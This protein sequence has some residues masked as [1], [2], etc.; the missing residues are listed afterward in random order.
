M[1][2]RYVDIPFSSAA[3]LEANKLYWV[4]IA[5]THNPG[6]FISSGYHN[7][8]NGG[9][10]IV[11]Y[12]TSGF[13][14]SFP[15]VLS[16]SNLNSHGEFAYWF[17]LYDPDASFLTGPQGPTGAAGPLPL[18]A[19]GNFDVSCNN[20]VDVSG[21][22]FCDGT[23]IGS[24]DSFDISMVNQNFKIKTIDNE[25]AFNI[26]PSGN[27]GIGAAATSRR[28][29]VRSKASDTNPTTIPLELDTDTQ[30]SCGLR[31]KCADASGKY[32]LWD[33]F[34]SNG[35]Q[36]QGWGVYDRDQSEYR[37]VIDGSS[38]N[39]GIGT[40]DPVARL[41]I[42]AN[43]GYAANLVESKTKAG[44][45]LNSQVDGGSNGLSIGEDTGTGS[46][47][48]S[49]S[50]TGGTTSY[51]INLNPWG[52]NV[53]IGT[54]DPKGVLHLRQKAGTGGTKLVFEDAS[55]NGAPGKFWFVNV[56]DGD[57]S[58]NACTAADGSWCTS[59]PR[60][61]LTSAGNVGIGTTEPAT[62][63]HIS[64][65]GGALTG[66]K[67]KGAANRAKLQVCDTDTAAYFIAEDS[68]VSIGGGDSWR[69]TNL[70]I[71]TTT[72]N[73]GIGTTDPQALLTISGNS[74]GG[75]DACALRIVDADDT[76]GSKIPA[77]MFYGGSDIQGR[78][79]GG[80]TSFS[81]AVGNPLATA[82][83]IDPSSLKTEIKGK[84]EVGGT[85]DILSS[86]LT[87]NGTAGTT[88]QILTT[89]GAD[90]QV[91]WQSPSISPPIK[92]VTK[93]NNR[94]QPTIYED[95]RIRL[96]L[97]NRA[98][99][100]SA[101]WCQIYNFPGPPVHI[102]CGVNG[103][104]GNPAI[105]GKAQGVN[106]NDLICDINGTD[107]QISLKMWMPGE[108]AWGYYDITMIKSNGSWTETPLLCLVDYKTL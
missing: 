95:A 59:K 15:A 36:N 22:Y 98:N 66:L 81:I 25:V 74:D 18:D 6:E 32:K 65:A 93:T 71:H 33:L 26:D 68:Y 106:T 63:L 30:T 55:H 77:I 96:W 73:V 97:Y 62:P 82:L 4:A 10:R 107:I 108:D 34:C 17:R 53:G 43:M 103:G 27:V 48:I 67:I 9:Y 19:S 24:G 39:V 46:Y 51:P 54:T 83:T 1:D 69:A 79:R 14:G 40:R 99:N 105:T 5:G 92:S 37:F 102:T 8:Y 2:Y 84:L 90:G 3:S 23:Y 72:G 87:I 101:L 60:L 57:F 47:F 11:Q 12:Q 88:G 70:N 21:I 58:I 42:V 28:L 35:I 7:D 50:N 61:T 89:T 56:E 78:I 52:G 75:D 94:N 85:L 31:F 64:Y 100:Y 41:Y 76:A 13:N 80:D 49:N 44:F 38:G 16:D 20:I 29:H 45:Y 91:G 86:K 104:F